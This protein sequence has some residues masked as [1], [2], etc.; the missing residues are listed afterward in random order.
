MLYVIYC[1][2][3]KMKFTEYIP[4]FIVR[5]TSPSKARVFAH[6]AYPKHPVN[7][8]MSGI[9]IAEIKELLVLKPKAPCTVKSLLYICNP[10]YSEETVRLIASALGAKEDQEVWLD[11][12]KSYFEP[13]P[14]NG[15]GELLARTENMTPAIAQSDY[16]RPIFVWKQVS[17]RWPN[18]NDDP[19]SGFVAPSVKQE[20]VEKPI[21]TEAPL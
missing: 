20:I 17:D 5:A 2:P 21:L 14:V 13:V 18:P 12:T 15:K 19:I 8:W 3:S 7:L 9:N 10:G 6:K 4:H 1:D 16:D 11:P